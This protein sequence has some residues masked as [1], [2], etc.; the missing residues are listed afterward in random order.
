MRNMN[1]RLFIQQPVNLLERLN[2]CR[3]QVF[4]I[5]EY[6]FH[7]FGFAATSYGEDW[8]ASIV[9]ERE[10]HCDPLRWW[11][12]GVG[13]IRNEPVSNTKKAMIWEERCSVSI[14]SNTEQ[15]QVEWRNSRWH[16]KLFANHSLVIA[17]HLLDRVI[18]V[19]CYK[20]LLCQRNLRQEVS[21][22]EAEMVS[23][24]ITEMKFAPSLT[25]MLILRRSR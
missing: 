1:S 22:V 2:P 24:N 15:Q 20:S 3:W 25:R 23:M 8:K 5:S 19:D 10:C 21:L 9:D 17:R 11:L 4:L 13:N 12:R 7:N 16:L 6:C 18:D 14:R